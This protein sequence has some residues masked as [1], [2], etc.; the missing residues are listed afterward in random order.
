MYIW[1]QA[2][3]RLC[4]VHLQRNL[5]K[6]LQAL[7]GNFYEVPNLLEIWRTLKSIHLVDWNSDLIVTYLN[8]LQSFVNEYGE[9]MEQ[10]IEYLQSTYFKLRLQNGS[11][12][13]Y[14]YRYWSWGQDIQSF[15]I[16]D[17]TSNTSEACNARLNR[18]VITSYQKFSKSAQTLWE[19]H[20]DL[21]DEYHKI[22]KHNHTP[23]SKRKLRTTRRWQYLTTNCE[24]FHNLFPEAQNE[25]L[26]DFL[27]KCSKRIPDPPEPL[28]EDPQESEI[29]K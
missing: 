8:Y 20:G 1:S 21:L 13:P 15:D 26:I 25:S 14:S 17:T 5:R 9:Q 6:R 27:L 12:D 11:F 29:E 7:F 4:S 24:D 10:F 22:F 23:K 18:N 19:S 16:A 3:I 28:E 2:T